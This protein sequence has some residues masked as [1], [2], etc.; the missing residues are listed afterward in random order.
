MEVKKDIE[1]ILNKEKILIQVVA[2]F[3]FKNGMLNGINI[4]YK[5][6]KF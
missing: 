2:S 1:W 4:H 3:L 5:I 6:E